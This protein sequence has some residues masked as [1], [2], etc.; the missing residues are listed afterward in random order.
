MANKRYSRNGYWI[1]ESLYDGEVLATY[2][3]TNDYNTEYYK[4]G[5]WHHCATKW[6]LGVDDDYDHV[7][8]EEALR[9]LGIKEW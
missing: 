8:E 1:K 7:S 2:R 3:V 6:E 9:A 4:D 5:K